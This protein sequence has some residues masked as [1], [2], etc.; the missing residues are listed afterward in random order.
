MSLQ[1]LLSVF[2][3]W[4]LQL[5]G[6]RSTSTKPHPES[7]R[8]RGPRATGWF[9]DYLKE[10]DGPSMESSPWREASRAGRVE[11]INFV[12][13]MNGYQEEAWK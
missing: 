8:G 6:N 2:R 10:K 13:L 12:K 5:L 3:V 1:T 7:S 4:A 9:A 11:E